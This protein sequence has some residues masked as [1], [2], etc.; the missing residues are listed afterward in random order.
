MSGRCAGR[1]K[2]DQT[3]LKNKT[4]FQQRKLFRRAKRFRNPQAMLAL[5]QKRRRGEKVKGDRAPNGFG[6]RAPL[7]LF[8]SASFSF[9]QKLCRS[10]LGALRRNGSS[11]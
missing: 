3:K 11:G 9:S 2:F 1:L 4:V 8:S 6:V 7:L 10:P 5:V